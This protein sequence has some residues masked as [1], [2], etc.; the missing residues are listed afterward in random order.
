MVY[1]CRNV[2]G[3]RQE[4]VQLDGA[5]RSRVPVD[6]FVYLGQLLLCKNSISITRTDKLTTITHILKI[7][8]RLRFFLAVE[9]CENHSN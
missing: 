5:G 8:V 6:V 9:Y 3:R 1:G 7:S 2:I 4:T